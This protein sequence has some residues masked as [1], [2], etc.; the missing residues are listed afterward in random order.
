MIWEHDKGQKPRTGPCFAAGTPVLTPEGPRPIETLRPGDIVLTADG[1]DQSPRPGPIRAVH[2]SDADRTLGLM[3][4]GE[5]VVAT[6]GHPLW[7][8][9]RGWTRAGDLRAGDEVATRRG[10]VTLD[11]VEIQAGAEVWNLEVD[12]GATYLVGRSG[13]IAHDLGPVAEIPDDR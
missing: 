12:D 4:G 8:V 13:L 1:P 11:A 6:E 7:K 5:A 3:V 2:R 9:G 10:P